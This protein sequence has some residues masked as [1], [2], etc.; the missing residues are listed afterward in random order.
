MLHTGFDAVAD[1]L[2]LQCIQQTF[3]KMFG[4]LEE[5]GL[6]YNKIGATMVA[7]TQ[8]QVLVLFHVEFR[9]VLI[10]IL[11]VLLRMRIYWNYLNIY[12]YILIYFFAFFDSLYIILNIAAS[13]EKSTVTYFVTASGK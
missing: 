12:L 7:W 9:Y 1:T 8:E 5:F 2:E 13:A 3:P 6:P 4:V 11:M 10:Y